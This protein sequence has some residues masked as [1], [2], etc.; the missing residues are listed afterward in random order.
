MRRFVT[1]VLLA[2]AFPVLAQVSFTTGK[3]AINLNNYGR[4]RVLSGDNTTRQIDRSSVLIGK[5]ATAVFDYLNDAE[6]IELPSVV[7]TPA[8]S[9]Y[10]L[11]VL[12]DN[13][14]AG[15][16]PPDVRVRINVYGWDTLGMAIV[17]FNATNLDTSPSYSMYYG[18]EIIP[19]I[20]G[21]YG[22]EAMRWNAARKILYTYKTGGSYIGYKI[23]SGSTATNRIIDWVEGYGTDSA[24][25]NW[26]NPGRIDTFLSTGSDGAVGFVGMPKINFL[27]NTEAQM[28]VGISLG[29]SE[30]DMFANMTKA[31]T[32]YATLVTSV[33]ELS[34]QPDGF[35]LMQNYPN[36]FNPSTE[37]RYSIGAEGVVTLR[38]TDVLGREVTT[39]V[40]ELQ[41]PGVYSAPFDASRLSG[42]TYFYTLTQG[43]R[44]VS[45][46]ML[47]IK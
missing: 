26:F 37:I 28:Y 23:L 36:P 21:V 33:R 41:R 16:S 7:T 38:V 30:A 47:L 24:Y 6:N 34:Q 32:K 1:L 15:A 17:K 45:K 27:R 20:D 13:S 25:Y 18:M 5:S 40:N 8:K 14:Y 43:S 44:S 39:L 2:F 35:G 42:G 12:V 9:N 29:A 19:Q 46:K 22:N 31:E 10:E 3:I 11:T 4:V